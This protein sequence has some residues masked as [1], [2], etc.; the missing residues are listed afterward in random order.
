MDMDNVRLVS[1]G[2]VLSEAELLLLSLEE[3]ATVYMT[4]GLDGGK[5][6]KKKKPHTTKKKTKH[7]HVTV[8]LATLKFYSVDAKGA[9]TY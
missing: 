2:H 7:R 6:K 5:K 1:E 4:A 9:I 8:P 3:D